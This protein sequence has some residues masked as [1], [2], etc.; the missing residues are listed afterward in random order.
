MDSGVTTDQR[1][2]W[3]QIL[4]HGLKQRT[5]DQR[6]RR[7]KQDQN[8][9]HLHPE[10]TINHRGSKEEIKTDVMTRD[11]S[12]KSLLSAVT[13]VTMVTGERQSDDLMLKVLLE[14]I[15]SILK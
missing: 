15:A 4:L 7:S 10:D 11:S 2:Q 14:L 13:M 6:Q 1:L 8:L 12:T 5:A 3:L 9:S